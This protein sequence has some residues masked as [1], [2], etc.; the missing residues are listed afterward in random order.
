MF[1]DLSTLFLVG[2]FRACYMVWEFL[3]VAHRVATTMSADIGF[4]GCQA[5][6]SDTILKLPRYYEIIIALLRDSYRVITR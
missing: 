5:G 4:R 2:R 6:S 3:P 1:T